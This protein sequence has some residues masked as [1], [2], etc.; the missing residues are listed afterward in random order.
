MSVPHSTLSSSSFIAPGNIPSPCPSPRGSIL[1]PEGEKTK[2]IILPLPSSASPLLLEWSTRKDGIILTSVK[3]KE[4]QDVS[5]DHSWTLKE[6]IKW[7]LEKQGI[8]DIKI[9]DLKKQGL[10]LTFP[11]HQADKIQSLLKDF[12][13]GFQLEG[14]YRSENI[15]IFCLIDLSF[16]E[17]FKYLEKKGF[18]QLDEKSQLS[19]HLPTQTLSLKERQKLVSF[20]KEIKCLGQAFELLLQGLDHADKSDRVKKQRD[21]CREK[22]KNLIFEFKDVFKVES[23]YFSNLRENY[24]VS[25]ET[26]RKL[27]QKSDEIGLVNKDKGSINTSFYILLLLCIRHGKK[28]DQTKAVDELISVYNQL[29]DDLKTKH[30]AHEQDGFSLS[31]RPLCESQERLQTCLNN[32]FLALHILWVPSFSKK[33]TQEEKNLKKQDALQ[34]FK[35]QLDILKRNLIE[36]LKHLRQPLHTP[37]DQYQPHSYERHEAGGTENSANAQYVSSSTD[38][39]DQNAEALDAVMKELSNFLEGM[40]AGSRTESQ[41]SGPSSDL[42]TEALTVLRDT[43]RNFGNELANRST[44]PPSESPMAI[45]NSGIESHDRSIGMYTP[46][47]AIPEIITYADGAN[48][49]TDLSSDLEKRNELKDS[50]ITFNDTSPSNAEEQATLLAQE[51]LGFEIFDVIKASDKDIRK[52]YPALTAPFET[53]VWQIFSEFMK[54]RSPY[55]LT[56]DSQRIRNLQ[57]ELYL[58]FYKSPLI[59]DAKEKAEK[60]FISLKNTFG[61]TQQEEKGVPLFSLDPQKMGNVDKNQHGSLYHLSSYI[62]NNAYFYEPILFLPYLKAAF[63]LLVNLSPE[64]VWALRN[65]DPLHLSEELKENFAPLHELVNRLLFSGEF[66]AYPAAWSFYKHA[67]A[68][69]SEEQFSQDSKLNAKFLTVQKEVL[70]SLLERINHAL[71]DRDMPAVEKWRADLVR[72]KQEIKTKLKDIELQTKRV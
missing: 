47:I 70:I 33:M 71:R 50:S 17:T 32:L 23:Y 16:I 2:K 52:N 41:Y 51:L 37:I 30:D 9:K 24:S 45:F 40:Q 49:L 25:L 63:N 22:I 72:I 26:I 43:L 5:G 67:I 31:F 60:A 61:L 65:N 36:S 55:F 6:N 62:K 7:F 48:A 29:L 11:P 69:L 38:M 54:A 58:N 10:E 46:S 39:A 44:A 35:S 27:I 34:N 66:D 18:V 42:S 57:A 12:A 56:F 68:Q 15:G 59:Q 3:N 28:E 20:L 19:L 13:Q 64:Y 1:F 4:G 14:A 53:P 8:K 21:Y